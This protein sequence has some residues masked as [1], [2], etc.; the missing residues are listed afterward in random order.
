MDIILGSQSPRRKE[1]LEYF[2][3]TFR[4]IASDYDEGNVIF[5]NDP[6]AY[7]IELSQKK[8]A[9]LA[10]K[11]PGSIIITADTIV[12]FQGRIFNKPRSSEEAFQMLSALSNHWHQVFTAVTVQQN[13]THFSGI[14]ETKILFQPLTPEQ[15]HLYHKSCSFLDK[16]GAY[17]IQ[18]AG[19]MV[20]K[21]IDGCYYNVMGLPINV[22]KELLSKIGIDLW[23]FLKPC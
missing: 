3:L 8:G 10:E 5:R 13:G 16:A 12:Y 22:L 14:E 7:A 21:H 17:A 4:Q 2:D 19:N 15:I 6:K 20:V 1:I 18:Q 11:H 23:K 9:V